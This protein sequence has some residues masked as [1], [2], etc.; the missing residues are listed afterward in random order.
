MRALP[1][2]VPLALLTLLVARPGFA[3]G[4]AFALELDFAEGVTPCFTRDELMR[5][6]AERLARATG[7]NESSQT[8]LTIHAQVDQSGQ[9]GLRAVIMSRR[10]EGDEGRRE[11]VAED[12]CAALLEPL[13]LVIAL[14]VDLAGPESASATV[15]LPAATEVPNVTP[16]SQ[17]APALPASED[18]AAHAEPAHPSETLEP[19]AERAPTAEPTTAPLALDLLPHAARIGWFDARDAVSAAAGVAVGI[20]P[21]AVGVLR[22]AAR[23]GLVVP[24]RGD[25]FVPV[26]AE[27]GADFVVPHELS[28]DPAVSINGVAWH[29][30]ACA[31][32]HHAWGSVGFEPCSGVWLR[33]LGAHA[34]GSYAATFESRD[35][36]LFGVSLGLTFY[37]PLG[38]NWSAFTSGQALIP[39]ATPTLR[40]KP[41]PPGAAQPR[42]DPPY[43]NSP[44]SPAPIIPPSPTDPIELYQTPAMAGT[45]L[46]GI[47]VSL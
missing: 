22:L 23:F 31:F 1:R 44:H 36:A 40:L 12:G 42:G 33:V 37:V 10:T 27:L 14:L 13:S 35:F 9:R 38:G 6:V 2:V 17:A 16:E 20:L 47:A 21:D 8:G 19:R 41:L 5:S 46:A 18:A 3:R 7:A 11:I 43:F 30:A 26:V 4:D 32:W 45:L 29:A 34:Q 25:E 15:G 24:A 28:G 39:F